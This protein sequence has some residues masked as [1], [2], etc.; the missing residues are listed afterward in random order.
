MLFKKKTKKHFNGFSGKKEV[1]WSLLQ[2]RAAGSSLG[3][4]AEPQCGGQTELPPSTLIKKA[5]V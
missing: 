4:R 1:A 2:C 5:K 3:S